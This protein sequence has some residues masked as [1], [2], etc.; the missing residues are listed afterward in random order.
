MFKDQ[1]LLACRHWVWQVILPV[2]GKVEQHAAMGQ[3]RRQPP[4]ARD[5][6]LGHLLLERRAD[7]QQVAP[8]EIGGWQ[9]RPQDETARN[10]GQNMNLSV[11]P[12][13]P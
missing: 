12:E 6:A 4:V 5:E 1:A 8:G 13:L 7:I 3:E 11:Q 9:G 2:R 10:I